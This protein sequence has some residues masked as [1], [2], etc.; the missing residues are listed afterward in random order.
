MN[1]SNRDPH[2]RKTFALKNTNSMKTYIKDRLIN[3]QKREK[4]K[5][6][7]ITKF[8]KKFWIKDPEILLE[9]EIKKFLEGE[10]LTDLDLKH[11]DEKIRWILNNSNAHEILRRDLSNEINDQEKRNYYHD[12]INSIK[13]PDLNNDNMSI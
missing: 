5:G 9:N 4:L 2:G 3:I 11:L 10:K 6:L 1:S 12:Y 7:L 13:L 8:M